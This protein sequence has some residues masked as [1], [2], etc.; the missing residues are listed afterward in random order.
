MVTILFQ[1]TQLAR[2]FWTGLD[3]GHL[4]S[5]G[6]VNFAWNILERKFCS[7]VWVTA[8]WDQPTGEL[9]TADLG[10]VSMAGLLVNLL[11]LN[12]KEYEDDRLLDQGQLTVSVFDGIRADRNDIVH[13]FFFHDP[14]KEISH[15]I[16]ISAKKRRGTAEI[17]SIAM[18]NNDI[19]TLCAAIS[20]CYDSIDDLVHKLWFRRKFLSGER[21]PFAQT[22]EYAVHG[23]RAPSFDIERLRNQVR[24]RSQRLNP[25]QG[26]RQPQ[27]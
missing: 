11:I 17:K 2:R 7:L 24:I 8:G 22:Y 21:G 16:K 18:S 4:A 15:N 25:P 10:N 3:D 5:I 14:T 9:V 13:S 27:S 12:L 1:N 20:D 23:W 6:F 26:Q 19:D